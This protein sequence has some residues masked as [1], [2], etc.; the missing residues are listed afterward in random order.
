VSQVTNGILLGS[1]GPAGS[2]GV[3]FFVQSGPPS[4]SSD[5]KVAAAQT[6]SLYSDFANGNLWFKT[7]SG[8]TQI[9]IP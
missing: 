4:A 2:A 3:Y 8:W 5:P 9:S 6:G 1:P 7:A